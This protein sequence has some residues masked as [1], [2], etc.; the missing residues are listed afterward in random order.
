MVIIFIVNR[1]TNVPKTVHGGK[2]KTSAHGRF[3]RCLLTSTSLKSWYSI[4]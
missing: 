2:K 4:D 1:D 3:R